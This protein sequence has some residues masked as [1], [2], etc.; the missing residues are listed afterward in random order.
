MKYRQTWLIHQDESII[1]LAFDQGEIFT[2]LGDKT[3]EKK[4][5]INEIELELV[6]GDEQA[7]FELS[8]KLITI[9]PMQPSNLSKAARGY[10]LYYAMKE[11]SN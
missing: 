9:I 10:S 3:T 8:K 11:A 2:A 7:L 6:S 5:F 1:E 4:L